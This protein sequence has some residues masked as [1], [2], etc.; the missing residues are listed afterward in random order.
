MLNPLNYLTKP[1]YVLRP[2]QTLRRVGRLGK[3]KPQL[4]DVTLPWGAV[5]I[6]HTDENIGSEIYHYGVF[7]KI[8]PEALWR[9]LDSGDVAVDVGANIGQNCSLMAAKVG[10]AGRVIAFEPHPEIFGELERNCK[11][12]RQLDFAP[13][14]LENLAL[15]QSNGEAILAVSESFASNRGSPALQTNVVRGQGIE[16]PVRRLDEFMEGVDHLGACKIDVEGLELQVLLGAEKT[17]RRR[18]IRDIIFEDFNEKPSP[19][20]E[21]LQQHGFT[22]FG[23]YDS[24]LKPRLVPLV[25]TSNTATGFSFNYL[26]TLDAER[27]CRRFKMPGW[28]CLLHL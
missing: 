28:R 5:V 9:L 25:A 15:G 22:I 26:A 10:P 27:A 18:A 23:L 19:T 17:L 6:V 12:W 14:Q 11:R 16:V 4:A 8:V 24:W 3:A 13:I 7:D 21:F 1:E 20:M 2:S